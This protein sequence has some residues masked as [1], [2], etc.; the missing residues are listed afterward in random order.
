VD[1]VLGEQHA[2]H[3]AVDDARAL[4]AR[5]VLPQ[6][7]EQ[8]MGRSDHG[9][10][11]NVPTLT[12]RKQQRGHEQPGGRVAA[13]RRPGVP[14]VLWLEHRGHLCQQTGRRQQ[15]M[16]GGRGRRGLLLGRQRL[17]RRL[18]LFLGCL[19]QT[20]RLERWLL[21]FF[22]LLLLARALAFSIGLAAS[23]GIAR[24][25][26]FFFPFFFFC[27]TGLGARDCGPRD[28]QAGYKG[29]GVAL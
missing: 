28:P 6:R 4:A 22:F 23:K 9:A 16:R 8:V 7:R 15:A 25:D 19:C 27:L 3:P 2:Y 5:V 26:A 21:L 14:D 20:S 12:A 1:R 11:L 13:Q 17:L 29:P 18:S 10:R 24:H